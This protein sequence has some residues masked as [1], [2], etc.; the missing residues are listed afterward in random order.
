MI[1]VDDIAFQLRVGNSRQRLQILRKGQREL[2]DIGRMA[3][4]IV[5]AA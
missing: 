3:I 2:V 4:V 5:A 1:A